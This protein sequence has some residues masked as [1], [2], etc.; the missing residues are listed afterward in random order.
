MVTIGGGADV[1]GGS[2]SATT[3][4][5]GV[6]IVLSAERSTDTDPSQSNT[7]L[8]Y[9]WSDGSNALESTNPTHGLFASST[10][11]STEVANLKAGVYVFGLKTTDAV[12]AA[13]NTT[14]RVRINNAPVV[15]FAGSLQKVVGD[16]V[17][18]A[19]TSVT[20]AD[21]D[22]PASYQWTV[23]SKPTSSA[24]TLATPTIASASINVDAVGTYELALTATDPH[25]GTG[26]GT[27]VIIVNPANENC[28][29]AKPCAASTCI[30][31]TTSASLQCKK[32]TVCTACVVAISE[33]TT[34]FVLDGS[35]STDLDAGDVAKALTTCMWSQESGVKTATVTAKGNATAC[36]ADVSGLIPGEYVFRLTATDSDGASSTADQ[37]VVVNAQPIADA[38]ESIV[39]QFP[40]SVAALNAS[41]SLD[42]DSASV[43]YKWT[44]VP[45]PA[46]ST[47]ALLAKTTEAVADAYN[48]KPGTAY[49][50]KV[51]VT[52]TEGAAAR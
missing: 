19:A 36:T 37:R 2:S 30:T 42:V 35:G 40:I 10:A 23:V 38:G 26:T 4:G 8:I 29:Q 24:A 11:Q 48:L 44:E 31:T 17:A 52:D 7:S 9:K 16:T 3:V 50:F 41:E 15:K 13:A 21:G 43:S 47:G 33:P 32:S 6:V 49:K 45:T 51:T 22:A 39:L 34:T 18:L 46:G 14:Q 5:T 28:P 1:E 12:G 27:I 20:D 25:G